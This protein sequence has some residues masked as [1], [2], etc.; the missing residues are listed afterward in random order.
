MIEA[1][2]IADL[3]AVCA[4]VVCAEQ[5]S[6]AGRVELRYK[7]RALAEIS[8]NRR[9]CG[10]VRG[11]GRAGDECTTVAVDGDVIRYVAPRSAEIRAVDQGGAGGIDLG[12]ERVVSEAVSRR[13]VGRD[14]RKVRGI[15]IAGHIRTARRVDGDSEDGVVPATTKVRAVD[16]CGAGGIQL[17]HKRVVEASAVGGLKGTG[18]HPGEIC[19]TGRAC[20]VSITARV[21]GDSAASLA[22]LA[23]VAADERAVDPHASGVEFDHERI[24]VTTTAGGPLRSPG[25]DR[26]VRRACGAGEIRRA[27]AVDGH[28]VAAFAAGVS[29]IRAVQ[30]GAAIR[31]DLREECVPT[32]AI[33]HLDR[34]HSREGFVVG[35]HDCRGVGFA[36]DV[37]DAVSIHSDRIAGF[38]AAA[39][40]VCAV[41]DCGA[42]RVQFRDEDVGGPVVRRLNRTG[43]ARREVH[44]TG[45]ACHIDAP[46]AADS[47]SLRAIVTRATEVGRIIDHGIDDQRFGRVVGRD[48]KTDTARIEETV[49]AIHGHV[50]AG[51]L[52]VH[53]RFLLHDVPGGRREN[54]IPI[55]VDRQLFDTVKRDRDA[56]RIRVGRDHEVILELAL[57]AVVDQIDPGIDRLVSHTRITGHVALPVR[58][59]SANEIVTE[60]LLTIESRKLRMRIG[61]GKLHAND[62]GRTSVSVQTEHGF[63]RGEEHGIPT[64]AGKELDAL[65]SLSPIRFECERQV[66][67]NRGS[68]SV[69][70]NTNEGQHK[71]QGGSRR[72][73]CGLQPAYVM[74]PAV[75]H[76]L[77]PRLRRGLVEGETTRGMPAFV[78][79]FRNLLEK[80]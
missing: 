24:I 60:T 42:R 61:T 28:A 30:K 17:R 43:A 38:S 26:K 3:A 66:A 51:G 37:G 33:V 72:H 62:R 15:G 9:D 53:D 36:C 64:A 48:F 5:E 1:D 4:T 18:V 2:S 47:K 32:E 11:T 57:F 20:D 39:A 13:L 80:R 12:Y 41:Q 10:K 52:L 19:R 46:I 21:N 67:V 56:V 14:R 34:C 23:P 74:R 77:L 79:A 27:G 65:V 63:G 68:A 8:L 69:N 50:L 25:R 55:D 31:T 22:E 54:E 75:E 73:E 7:H 70:R 58:G 16:E 35:G 59:I 44:G 45:R 76:H 78:M 6:A 40:E 71:H 29:V 49:R